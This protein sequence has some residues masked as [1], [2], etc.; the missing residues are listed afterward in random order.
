MVSTTILLSALGGAITGYWYASLFARRIELY[1]PFLTQGA[2]AK[3]TVF[4]IAFLLNYVLLTVGL[5]LLMLYLHCN[6]LVLL[7]ALLTTFWLK[8]WVLTRRIL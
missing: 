4:W 2:S 5:V 3:K 6:P 7:S 8:V 1:K